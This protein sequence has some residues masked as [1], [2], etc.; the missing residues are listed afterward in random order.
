VTLA[1]VTQGRIEAG[2]AIQSKLTLNADLVGCQ[3]ED[4]ANVTKA[5]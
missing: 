1:K 4:W 5:L 2:I 3:I